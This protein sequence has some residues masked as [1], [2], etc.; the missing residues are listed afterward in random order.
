VPP[1]KILMTLKGEMLSEY[2]ITMLLT[3]RYRPYIDSPFSRS[4]ALQGII[5]SR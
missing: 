2:D 5:E 3:G 1:D 4:R